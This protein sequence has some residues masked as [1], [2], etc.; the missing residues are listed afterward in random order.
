MAHHIH[1]TTAG[2]ST[3]DDIEVS[4]LPNFHF[5]TF[6]GLRTSIDEYGPDHIHET[7]PGI[8]TSTPVATSEAD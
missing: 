8:N 4:G 7:S 6:D 5:H 3:S 2:Q 1:I